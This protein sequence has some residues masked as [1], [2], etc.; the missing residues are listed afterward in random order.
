[1]TS[2]MKLPAV[3]IG[4]V[5]AGCGGSGIKTHPVVGKIETQSGD[6]TPLAGHTVEVALDTSPEVRASGEIRDDG[7]FVLETLQGGKVLRGAVPGTYKARIVLSDDDASKRM[8]A[9]KTVPPR[10][11][12]FEKSGLSVHVPAGE[13]VTFKILRR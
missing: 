12:Q 1:M 2:Q 10:Y 8:L 7:S 9:A 5:L 11:L 6:I 13:N 4:L 3:L